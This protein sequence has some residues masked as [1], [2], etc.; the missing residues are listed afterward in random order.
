MKFIMIFNMSSKLRSF[1][2]CACTSSVH[3]NQVFQHIK[4]S[5]DNAKYIWTM[6]PLYLNLYL[7]FLALVALGSGEL[8]QMH[9]WFTLMDMLILRSSSDI[10]WHFINS[11]FGGKLHDCHTNINDYKR[12]ELESSYDTQI[13]RVLHMEWNIYIYGFLG[14]FSI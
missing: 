8:V 7:N 5:A 13:D 2:V 10:R 6:W 4:L 14:F 11:K 3:V 9:S 12:K 1:I